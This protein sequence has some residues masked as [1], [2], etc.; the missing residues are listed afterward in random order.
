MPPESR[1]DAA[2]RPFKDQVFHFASFNE[3]QFVDDHYHC[4]VCWKTV[5][6]PEHTNVEHEGYVTVHEVHY[7]GFP[8][9]MQYA[10]ACN[11]CFPRYRD[12]Y[13]WKLSTESVPEIPEETGR[14]FNSAYQ[15][16]LRN[17]GH[18]K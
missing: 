17:L 1:E 4:I 10:W 8:V 11:E 5:A 6:G 9:A 12:A 7:T 14:A 13:G 18:S 3:R 2:L 16:Y 15:Q